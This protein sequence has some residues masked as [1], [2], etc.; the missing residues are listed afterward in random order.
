MY[1]TTLTAKALAL[2]RRQALNTSILEAIFELFIFQKIHPVH[3]Q[4]AKCSKWQSN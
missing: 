2:A 3:N 4:L 1:Y